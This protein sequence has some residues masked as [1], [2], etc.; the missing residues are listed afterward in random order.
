MFFF[1]KVRKKIRICEINMCRRKCS[2]SGIQ[3]VLGLNF[4]ERCFVVCSC[5]VISLVIFNATELAL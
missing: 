1:Y 5:F 2:K 4:M 3:S